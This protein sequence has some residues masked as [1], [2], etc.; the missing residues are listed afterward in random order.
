MSASSHS[1]VMSRYYAWHSRIYDATRWAFLFGRDAVIR[2]LQLKPGQTVV[3]IGCGTG[4]NLE[5]I[6]RRVGPKGQIFAVDC[7][8]PM[9]VRCSAR[10]RK[11]GFTNVQLVDREYGQATI[12]GGNAD[13]VVMSYSLSMIPN[14]KSALECAFRELRPGG[15]IGVVDFCLE[16]D[17]KVA[18]G[19]ASWM[20]V[21]L[22]TMNR[23][24]KERLGSLFFPLKCVTRK[25]FGGLWSFYWFV[26]ERR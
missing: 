17:S 4:R 8:K 19:F 24:Y 14:W 20:N 15:R 9:I 16:N 2:E 13:A 18:A 25:A 26:G 12:T 5:D 6:V 3:E 1:L 23:D 21:N 11:H 7:A 10:I 22:V